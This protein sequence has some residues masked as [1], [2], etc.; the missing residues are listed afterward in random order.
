MRVYYSQ[1]TRLLAILLV[2]CTALGCACQHSH[3]STNGIHGA[4]AE[5]VSQ[6]TFAAPPGSVYPE[7]SQSPK[8]ILTYAKD[9]YSTNGEV[10]RLL[11]VYFL[12]YD[13]QLIRRGL[14]TASTASD[15]LIGVLWDKEALGWRETPSMEKMRLHI[16]DSTD[17]FCLEV[18]DIELLRKNEREFSKVAESWN[19]D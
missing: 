1:I 13:S 8:D 10:R 4:L 7:P 14:V 11:A 6:E 2:V 5:F 17:R 15:T 16:A 9:N 19:H 12:E 18:S 3:E